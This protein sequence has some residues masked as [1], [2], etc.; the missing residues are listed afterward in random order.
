VRVLAGA[1]AV[2]SVRTTVGGNPAGA[3]IV[4]APQET[5]G[6]ESRFAATQTM[7]LYADPNTVVSISYVRSVTDATGKLTLG[8]SGY[9]ID[10]P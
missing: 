6:R 5:F 2:V 1:A 10:K 4:L 3:E 8:F 9:L 7:R